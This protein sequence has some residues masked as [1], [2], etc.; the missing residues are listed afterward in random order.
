MSS[1]PLISCQS[2]SKTYGPQTLFSDLSLGFFQGERLG[3]I[4][5]N[6][7]GKTT[8]L[9][10]MADLLEPSS[11]TVSRKRN[12]QLSY[13]SQDPPLDPEKTVSDILF[14][15]MPEM[16]ENW[17]SQRDVRDLVTGIA[18]EDMNQKAGTLSGGWR[19]RLSIAHALLQKPDI[20]FMDEP[21]NHLDLEGI[22]WLEKHLRT[23][24][25]AFVLV[26]HDRIFLEQTTNRIV[27]LNRCYPEGYLRI[28]GNYSEFLRRRAEFLNAQS[29]HEQTLASK[30]RREVSWLSRGPKARTT[31]AQF[32]IDQAGR[33]Q[34]DLSA[35]KARNDQG[36]SAQ[37]S[38]DATDRRTKILL[39]TI[40]L[41]MSRAGKTLF[42]NLDLML[43]PG[44]C[45]GLL[46]A[47]G[48]GKST[49]IDLLNGVLQPEKGKIKK[50]ADL[51]IVTFG[52]KR[53]QLDQNQT[54]QQAL[55]PEGGEQVIFQGRVIH[56]VSWAK[57][58]L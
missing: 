46:G 1:S 3:L 11:G 50:A 36:Q 52:Q 48:S 14:E 30:V 49:L 2:I 26:S 58:F 18:F 32:R 44:F 13:L 55:A 42:Q 19:K 5:P 37:F 34:G 24:N 20:L 57:R 56:I 8:L 38:F 41:G 15:E 16:A 40:N 51:K 31:K 35:V 54:V 7:S 17:V 9:K 6:G 4:G 27:E 28:E 43:S 53:E 45:L 22:L 25:F 47:N 23:S 10:V 33:L 29:Q 21:T 12:L 39:E